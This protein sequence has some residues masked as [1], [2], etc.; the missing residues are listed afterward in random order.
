MPGPITHFLFAQHLRPFLLSYFPFLS[1]YVP[2]Y[3]AGSL[4][5]DPFFFYGAFSIQN[6]IKFN[7]R[8]F[9]KQLHLQSPQETFQPLFHHLSQRWMDKNQWLSYLVGFLTHYVLDETLHPYVF[10]WSG[11]DEQGG[12]ESMPYKA[13][14]IR[15]EHSLDLA[16]TLANG[17]EVQ[18]VNPSMVLRN[19]DE[20]LINIEQLYKHVYGHGH[21]FHQSYQSMMQAYD[22]VYLIKDWKRAVLGCLFS[23]RSYLYALTHDRSITQKKFTLI[24]NG[25]Q[26]PWRHPSLGTTHHDDVFSLSV[27]AEQRMKR[28]TPLLHRLF[29]AFYP[30]T[31]INALMNEIGQQNF[32][33][34]NPD[35]TKRYF[36]SI[37]PA[38]RQQPTL[39]P[40]GNN[41][42]HTR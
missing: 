4:G 38:Y 26:Q 11:F 20:V 17:L 16:W 34:D 3:D 32:D 19:Q 5:P 12:I 41:P 40:Y 39:K 9:G 21:A 14:H 31:I 37:Y 22:S 18:D 36:Q 6:K 33:G 8:A 24:T 25:L 42:V 1:S 2:Y 15:F 23:K 10:Y 13:D 30:E 28:L 29:H 27:K 35:A 7:T